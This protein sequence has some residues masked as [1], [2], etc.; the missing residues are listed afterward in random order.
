MDPRIVT[1]SVS[2]GGAAGIVGRWLIVALACVV[3]LQIELVWNRPVNWDEAFHLSEAHA[4]SQGRLNETLQVLHVR[5]FFW[6]PMLSFDAVDQIRVARVFMLACELFTTGA[7]FAIGRRFAD[8]I[9][10]ALAGLAYLTAGYVFQ[11]GFSY[12]ADPMAAALLMG[13]LWILA[14]SRLRMP[15]ILGAGMLAALATVTTIK[16]VL[17]LPA[18]SGIAWLRWQ[19]AEDRRAMLRSLAGFTVTAAAFTV[20][21]LAL[22]V[23]TLPQSGTG[24]AARTISRSSTMMFS[25]GLFPQWPFILGAIIAAPL[26]A[27]LLILTP[28]ELWRA[29]LTRPR[30]IA[31]FL[32]IVPLTSIA[33]YRNSFP[34][35]YS[36]ILP[37]VMVAVSI[38][39]Q[40]LV[41]RIPA[42]LLALA[43]IANALI[44]SF[45]TPREVLPRQ[46][47]VLAAAHAIFPQ[48]V[49]YFDFPGMLPDFPKANFFMTSWGMRNYYAGLEP[50]FTQVMSRK[51]V[52]LLIVDQ[53]SLEHNQM[54]SEPGWRLLDQ[55]A[56]ALREG[57][58]PHWGPLW[59]AGRHFPVAETQRSFI[60]YTPG[61]YTLEGAGAR[62]DST[63]FQPGQTLVLKRGEHRFARLG[64]GDISLRWGNHL[65][66]PVTPYGGGPVFKDF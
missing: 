27:M 9:A 23:L 48:P 16:V 58:I 36:Y 39:M 31:L 53:D 21:A 61:E 6:L 7:I 29:R 17:Y 32:F 47:Q 35:F 41:A 46:K 8:P 60:I 4:F 64:E 56:K 54:G 22:T 51:I 62:I 33:F 13:S 12:R 5:A 38:A 28:L 26:A 52:P 25:G 37:P 34:Y 44:S 11:H 43:L 57:F 2:E 18:F 40:A 66:R 15:A 24:S 42:I 14:A 59:V 20:I 55:D 49:A 63:A 10:A 1:R 19:E 30:R 50:S 65:K 3:L 45:A